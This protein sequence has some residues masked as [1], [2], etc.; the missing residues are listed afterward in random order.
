MITSRKDAISIVVSQILIMY[1]FLSYIDSKEL[2]Q[3]TT[4]KSGGGNTT[5]VAMHWASQ[6]CSPR[7]NCNI[8]RS[9]VCD[10]VAMYGHN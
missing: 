6:Q 8:C 3:M 1:A 4:V 7:C 10:S 5:W 2:F 9:V